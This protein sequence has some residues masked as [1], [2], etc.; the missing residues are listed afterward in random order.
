[1]STFV[2]AIVP[3]AGSATRMGGEKQRL[4]LNGRPVLAHTLS[5]LQQTAVID[6]IVVVARKADVEE[7]LSYRE[8]FGITKLAA[9]VV[10]GESRQQSVANGLAAVS[11]RT[12]LVAIHDGARPLVTA[13]EMSTRAFRVRGP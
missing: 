5:V 12:T 2:S 8:R 11:D 3:A 7:F 1:M 13:E 4:L 9:V 10:G 6:E